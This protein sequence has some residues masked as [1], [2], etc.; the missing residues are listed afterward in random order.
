[1]RGRK[2]VLDVVET[3]YLFLKEN[4]SREY[5]INQISNKMKIQYELCIKCLNHLK[6]LNLIVERKGA[7]KPL[8]ERLFRFKR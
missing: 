6:K 5:P 1:M 2:K 8:Q 4:R 7:K 3:I